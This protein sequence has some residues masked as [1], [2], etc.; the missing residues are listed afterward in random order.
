MFIQ[1]NN[2]HSM[3]YEEKFKKEREILDPF[4]NEERM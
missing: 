3:I 4:L 1:K 2:L